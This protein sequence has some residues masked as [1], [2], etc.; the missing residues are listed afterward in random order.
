MVLLV[1]AL[2]TPPKPHNRYDFI[3]VGIAAIRTL[4]F[5]SL[6]I[7]SEISRT[8]PLSIPDAE[9]STQPLKTNGS[10]HYGTFDAGPTHPHAGRGGFGTNPPP[11]GGWITYL[12]SF[13]VYSLGAYVDV[14][15]LPAFVAEYG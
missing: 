9:S 13:K 10:T 5:F 6:A 2:T 12:K 8:R 7:I 3:Y 4:L 14:D 15:I 1:L 11:Q